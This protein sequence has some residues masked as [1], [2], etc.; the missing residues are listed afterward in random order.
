MSFQA[1]RRRFNQA[2]G[3]WAL[4]GLAGPLQAQIAVKRGAPAGK[5]VV[6]QSIPMTGAASEIGMAF[7]GGAKLFVSG[8]N[9]RVGPGGVTLELRQLDDGYS[10][11]KARANANRLLA[12]GAEVLFGFVG[13]A[14]AEAGAS[15]AQQQG[16]PFFAPFAAAD[17]LR[18]KAHANVFHVRPSLADEAY[19]MLRQCDTLGQK[20]IAVVVDDDAMGRA[21]LQAV[22]DAATELKLPPPVAVARVAPGGDQVSEAVATV[23]KAHPQAVVQASLSQTTAAFVREMRKAGY[24]SA[25]LTFSVVGIDPLYTELGKEIRGVIISQVVPS[26]RGNSRTPVV[27]EYLAAL[28]D[29]D[30]TASYEGLE[31]FIAAKSLAEAVHRAGPAPA[32]ASLLKAMAGMNDYDVG[33][34]RV[35][36]RP[37]LRDATRAVDLVY[38]TAEGRVLR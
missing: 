22:Q 12:E 17:A 25:L 18:D 2:V 30:Q 26:P 7:A 15:V 36:L 6:G 31:G 33:G 23:M 27:K 13:T 1:S 19:A 34:F 37:P 8:Y 9:D 24:G 38:I 10:A 5:L 14:S 28:A 35:N 3:A 32:R 16:A 20:R 4:L 29:S 11:D 21:A